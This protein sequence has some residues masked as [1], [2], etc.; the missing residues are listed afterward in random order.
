MSMPS[1][2]AL[3]DTT[4]RTTPSRSPF[5]ISRRRLRQIAAAISADC[6]A[7]RLHRSGTACLEIVL[8][9]GRQDLGRQTA[10]GEHDQLQ[11]ALQEL[12][13]HPSRLGKVRPPDAELM[14]DDRRVDEDEELLAARRAAPVDELEGL[15]GEP[16]GQLARIGDRR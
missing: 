6:L 9:V 8:Q 11:I 13:G 3:V 10:L 1:S 16:F 4:A 2:S 5:S 15:L 7:R 14:V 12:R